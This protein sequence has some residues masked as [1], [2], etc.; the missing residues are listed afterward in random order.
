MAL[1]DLTARPVLRDPARSRSKGSPPEALSPGVTVAKRSVNAR[2]AKPDR[3][4]VLELANGEG[5]VL[6]VEGQ[7]LAVYKNE[8]GEIQA[9]SGVCTHLGCII[10]W[11]SAERTW[12]C[13]CHG[14]RFQ[15]VAPSSKARPR[16]RSSGSHTSPPATPH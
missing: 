15:T 13:A 4:P 5:R 2:L 1:A 7:Q 16:R 10:D 8:H 9:V 12:D 6:T 11:N 3:T 14:S